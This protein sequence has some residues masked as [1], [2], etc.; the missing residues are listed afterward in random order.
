VTGEKILAFW[1]ADLAVVP[2]RGVSNPA[3]APAVPRPGL[4]E[5]WGLAL[6][7]LAG[8]EDSPAPWLLVSWWGVPSGSQ[9]TGEVQFTQRDGTT[10]S[11][12]SSL[13]GRCTQNSTTRPTVASRHRQGRS[14]P[15]SPEP[16]ALQQRPLF[17]PHVAA[18][19][20]HTLRSA[21]GNRRPRRPCPCRLFLPRLRPRPPV[22]R[23]R[24]YVPAG[25]AWGAAR[26]RGRRGGRSRPRPHPWPRP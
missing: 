16:R 13:A 10:S 5:P 26:P 7:N 24:P 22:D 9:A 4:P 17:S 19:A 23:T 12:S 6:E 25:R 20:V 14:R 1:T 15:Q 8:P 2:N 18:Q 21:P 3:D 11:G